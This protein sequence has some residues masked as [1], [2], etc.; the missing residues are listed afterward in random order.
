M[1]HDGGGVQGATEELEREKRA[2]Q[3]GLHAKELRPLKDFGK[4]TL[5]AL[6]KMYWRG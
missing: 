5:E 2:G 3:R 6:R 1:Q 4:F